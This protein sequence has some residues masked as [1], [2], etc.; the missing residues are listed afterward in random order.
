MGA[1]VVREDNEGGFLKGDLLIRN[2]VRESEGSALRLRREIKLR[3]CKE[4]GVQR[5][6]KRA[7]PPK[8]TPA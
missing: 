2:F 1:C 8:E 5:K 4:F 6:T 3:L 7:T